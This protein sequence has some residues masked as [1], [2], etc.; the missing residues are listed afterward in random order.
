MFCG[1]GFTGFTAPEIMASH[2]LM[3]Q[4]WFGEPPGE[5]P[6]NPPF[7]VHQIGAISDFAGEPEVNLIVCYHSNLTRRPYRLSMCFA[8]DRTDPGDIAAFT[9]KIGEPPD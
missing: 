9:P 4:Y 7:T 5:P 1:L 6:V 8:G 2:G 3:R